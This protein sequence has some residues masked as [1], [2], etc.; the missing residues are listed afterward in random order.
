MCPLL[1]CCSL[2]P[3]L[4]NAHTFSSR[5]TLVSHCPPLN[6]STHARA[7]SKQV[8]AQLVLFCQAGPSLLARSMAFAPAPFSFSCS[9]S[10]NVKNYYKRTLPPCSNCRGESALWIVACA[11]GMVPHCI[12]V[13]FCRAVLACLD[14]AAHAKVLLDDDVVHGSHDESDLHGVCGAGEVGVDLLGRML[15]EAG[16]ARLVYRSLGHKFH[17]NSRYKSVE[18][19]I[20]RGAVVLATLVVG[21]VVLH[22]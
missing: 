5:S 17:R 6:F 11:P 2:S 14:Q 13:D 9:T 21:E 15:V 8:R 3:S 10:Q 16:I 22:R 12:V 19:V 4:S 18:D 20:A 1:S 7:T